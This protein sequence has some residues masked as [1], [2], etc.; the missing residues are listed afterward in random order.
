MTQ[1]STF[2]VFIAE[3]RRRRVFR[4]AAVYGGVAFVLFQIIDSIFEP[5]HI[6]EWI[7][8]LIIVLLLV[9]FPLAA[10]LAWVFDITPEGIVRTKGKTRTKQTKPLTGNGA[11]IAVAIAAVAFGIWGRWAGG[12]NGASRGPVTYAKSVAVLPFSNLGNDPDQEFFSDGFTD[13][14]LINLYKFSNLN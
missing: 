7:G 11:L 5:L 14:I 1:Q 13:N 4:V 3:L 6:P 2:S 10:G 9:G 8:S 12:S